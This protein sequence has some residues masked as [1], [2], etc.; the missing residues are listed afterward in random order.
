MWL[1]H[2]TKPIINENYI[3]EGQELTHY[4][5]IINTEVIEENR[6]NQQ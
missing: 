6:H 3:S 5:K 2:P 4:I 1:I